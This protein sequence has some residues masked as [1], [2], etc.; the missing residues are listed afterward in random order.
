MSLEPIRQKID[1]L[2]KQL[3]T[4]INERLALAA[5]IGKIKRKEG[6]QIYVAEREDAVLRKVTGQNDGPI[7]NE[8]LR[9]LS[10]ISGPRQATR[11]RRR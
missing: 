9:C 5:E 7:K 8:A 11:T 4:I 1:E 10:R 3:V 2:D 6:G